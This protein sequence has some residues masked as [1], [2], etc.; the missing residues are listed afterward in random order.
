[1]A[2]LDTAAVSKI[3]RELGQRMELEGGNPYRARAY[4]RAA[5]NLSLSPMPLEYL[6]AEGRLTDIP[7]IG[8]ALAAIIT[9]LHQTG[10]HPYLESMLEATPEGVLEMLSIPGLRPDRIRKLHKELGIASIADLEDAARSGWLAATKGYGPRPAGQGPA[11]TQDEP[12]AAGPPPSSDSGGRAIRDR[13]TRSIKSRVDDDHGCRRLSP[14]LRT[15]R[16]FGA[17]RSRSRSAR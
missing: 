7:G 9:R 6:V 13:G 12:K 17:G 14:R 3:L 16:H 15:G 1:M 5:E 10:T 4:R 8:D 11:G 2:K